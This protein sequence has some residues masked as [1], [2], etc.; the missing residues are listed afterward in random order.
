MDLQLE[1]EILIQKLHELKLQNENILSRA[2]HS[3]ELCRNL[4]HKLKKE[5]I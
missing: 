1:S 3:I 5:I 2:Y 4:L